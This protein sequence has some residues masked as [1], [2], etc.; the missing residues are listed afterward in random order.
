M[1]PPPGSTTVLTI[2]GP[3]NRPDLPGLCARL[4]TLL[5]RSRADV[6]CDVDHRV[7]SD[8]VTIDALARLGLAARRMGC[9]IRLREAPAGLHELIAFAGLDEVIPP[10]GSSSGPVIEGQHVA[11]TSRPSRGWSG[12]DSS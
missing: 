8:L 11:G 2:R 10:V 1:A 5:E 7:E 4:R 9:G 6:L 3:L 12:M